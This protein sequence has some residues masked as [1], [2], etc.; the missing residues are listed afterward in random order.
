MRLRLRSCVSWF[1]SA[2]FRLFGSLQFFIHIVDIW[3]SEILKRETLVLVREFQLLPRL[4]H[5]QPV[6]DR[7]LSSAAKIIEIVA[8]VTHL[9]RGCNVAVTRY[10]PGAC[11]VRE[12]LVERGNPVIHRSVYKIRKRL[13]PAHIAGEHHVGVGH[14]DQHIAAG[15][16]WQREQHHVEPAHLT[17]ELGSLVLLVFGRVGKLF[18]RVGFTF[19]KLIGR[20]EKAPILCRLPDRDIIVR[21]DRYV[22]AGQH[23]IATGVIE[24]IV[25]IDRVPNWLRR[26]LADLADKFL[27]RN[28]SEEC[29]DDEHSAVAN[30]ESGVARCEPAGLGDARIDAV[31]DFDY[32]KVIF[33]LGRGGTGKPGRSEKNQSDDRDNRSSPHNASAGLVNRR[34]PALISLALLRLGD[35]PLPISR[36]ERTH[37]HT[38]PPPRRS[39]CDKR[40]RTY[41]APAA[42]GSSARCAYGPKPSSCAP[43]RCMSCKRI[44]PNPSLRQARS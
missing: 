34:E 35:S 13:R 37:P 33:G 17:L 9:G 15:V 1:A 38:S 3:L 10:E 22:A 5:C 43:R 7:L 8:K 16:A 31:S 12:N 44:S 41:P 23:L 25:S 26:Q 4:V 20:R 28:R 19:L 32:L 42:A 14:K 27:D 6:G 21:D 24:V 29:I 36:F 39:P 2:L 30:H 11:M 18:R 40:A